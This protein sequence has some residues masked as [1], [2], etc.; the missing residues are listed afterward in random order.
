VTVVVLLGAP[1]AGK[2]TQ[3]AVLRDRLGLP[4]IS[5]GDLFRAAVREGTELGIQAKRYMDAGQLVPD[6]VTTAMLVERLARPDAADGAILDGF[7]RTR[8]QAEALDAVLEEAGTGVAAA[9]L[10]EVPAEALVDRLSDRWV[11]QSGAH[12]YNALGN[13]PRTPGVCDVDATPLRQRDDDRPEIIRA[14]LAGQLDDLDAVVD[15]YRSRGVLT[16][17]DGLRPIDEVTV[18]LEAAIASAT[19]R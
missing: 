3:A 13:P 15:H 2:G 4:H 8:A 16:A 10:I 5:T 11:C 14:R 19:G 7:P 6:A 12:I 18:A 9:L 1:G 17:V